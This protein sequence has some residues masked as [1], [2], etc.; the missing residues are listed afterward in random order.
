[1]NAIHDFA[2]N[3]ECVCDGFLKHEKSERNQAEVIEDWF[4]KVNAAQV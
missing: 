2:Q 4:G 3:R 1:M